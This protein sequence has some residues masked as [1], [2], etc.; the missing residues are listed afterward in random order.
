MNRTVRAFAGRRTAW[1]SALLLSAAQ[2]VAQAQGLPARLSD[3][4]FWSL[5]TKASEA[6]G[7]FQS[8]NLVSNEAQFV[9]TM[10]TLRSLAQGSLATT[11]DGEVA[12]EIS[13]IV[14]AEDDERL[15]RDARPQPRARRLA[16]C[17]ELHRVAEQV[18]QHEVEQLGRDRDPRVDQVRLERDAR[19]LRAGRPAPRG[20]RVH[21][22][23]LGRALPVV[24]RH[25]AGPH[26]RSR[27]WRRCRWRARSG[28]RRGPPGG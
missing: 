1:L 25:Q 2:L 23:R 28:P 20:A 13:V 24:R 5:V 26:R 9:D 8:D 15:A 21:A 16:P 17:A 27:R 22:E 11:E 14:P 10:R 19:A 7:F 6:D 3:Q 4:E 18:R 12:A